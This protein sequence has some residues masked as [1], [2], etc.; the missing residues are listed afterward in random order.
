MKPSKTIMLLFIAILA[1]CCNEKRKTCKILI[2]DFKNL[3]IDQ[4]KLNNEAENF[5]PKGEKGYFLFSPDL[6]KPGYFVLVI[7]NKN[8]DLYL[9]PG[10]NLT[11]PSGIS[12]SGNK[13]QFYGKGSIINNYILNDTFLSEGI[14]NKTN[15]DSIY[16][17]APPDFTYCIDSLYKR[18]ERNLEDF[19]KKNRIKDEVFTSTERK[20]IFYSSAIEKNKYYRDHRFLTGEFPVFGREFD[21]YLEMADF[22]DSVSL[23]LQEY[24]KFLNTYFERV[25]LQDYNA[26]QNEGNR[27]HFTEYSYNRAKRTVFDE[28]VNSFQPGLQILQKM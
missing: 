16:S 2:E 19:I 22:N 10:Y 27:T 7:G 12:C 17:L 1:Y 9:A 24:K 28:K 18:R 6:K 8:Y 15:F 20:R 23:H 11:I 13:S 3:M 14:Q 26:F 4:L 5:K 21:R 25:G